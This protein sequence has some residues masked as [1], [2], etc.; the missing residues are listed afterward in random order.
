MLRRRN[1]RPQGQVRRPR[2][3]GFSAAGGA[4]ARSPAPSA[5]IKLSAARCA[6]APRVGRLALAMCGVSTTFGR[7]SNTGCKAGSPSNT[8]GAAAALRRSPRTRAKA[9]S[10]TMPPR[11]MLARRHRRRDASPR[12]RQH[13]HQM[14]AVAQQ[15]RLADTA[16]TQP[17]LHRRIEPRP[18]VVDHRHAKTERA[19]PRNGLADAPHAQHTQR[20]A[21]HVG[22]GKH[23]VAPARPPPGTQELFALADAPPSIMNGSW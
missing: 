17:R 19:A 16:G 14:I 13:Q 6:M 9:T 3:C 18:V 23:V 5:A 2:T 21:M 20:G 22:T 1:L 4:P 10:S 12:H 7:L 11:A 8:S 15:Q